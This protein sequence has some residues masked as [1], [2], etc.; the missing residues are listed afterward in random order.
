MTHAPL[1]HDEAQRL[2]ALDSLG[3]LDAAGSPAL[4]GLVRC[5]SAAT[6]CAIALVSLVDRDRQWVLSRVGLDVQEAPRNQSFCAHA[7]LEQGLFVVPDAKADARFADNPLVTG[8]PGIRFYAG[9]PL[10]VDGQ[11]MGTLCVADRQPH[12]LTA[13]Q[14]EVLVD[15]ARAAEQL[16][17][18]LRQQRQLRQLSTAVEQSS[19][20]ILITDLES[21]IVYVN[22]AAVKTSGYR[23]DELIGH[24]ARL[25][26]S[27]RTPP[28]AFRSLRAHLREGQPWKGLFFNRTKSG[29]E[30]TVSA[31]I[32][33]IRQADGKVAQYLAVMDDVTSSR[34]LGEE[35][36]RHRHHVDELV[37]ERTSELEQARLAA[38]AANEAKSAFLAAMSHEIRT[39]MNGVVGI[40]DVLRQSSLT[41]HQADLAG[42]IR[43]SSIAL[44][45]IIDDILDFSKAEAGAITL[46]PEPTNL[47]CLVESVC[48]MLQPMAAAR[49]VKV[50]VFVDP[51]LPRWIESDPLRLRQILHNLVGNAIKFSAGLDH[52]GRISVRFERDGEQGLRLRV[53]DNGIGISAQA[54]AAIFEPFDQGDRHTTRRYGG[55]GLGLA[56]CRRLVELFEGEISVDSIEGQG[57]TFSVTMPITAVRGPESEPDGAALDGIRCLV[58]LPDVEQ[59][60]DWCVYLDAAGA[61]ASAWSDLGE[62]RDALEVDADLPTVVLVDAGAHPGESD[63]RWWPPGSAGRPVPLVR[64]ELGQRRSPRLVDAGRVSLDADLVHR[65]AL[66]QAVLLAVGRPIQ[67]ATEAGRLAL[68]DAGSAATALAASDSVRLVLV[69]E[70]NEINQTV[71]RHQL[72][73][74]GFASEVV[75]NGLDALT[76][77]RRQRVTRRYALL[78]TD[79]QMP[80][81]DGCE[82]AATIRR[83]ELPAER[84]PIVAL[85]ANA[86]SEEALRCL[87]AG[88]DDVVTKPV[89]LDRLRKLLAQWLPAIEHEAPSPAPLPL[90]PVAPVLAARPGVLLVDDEPLE[91][92]I[93]ERQLEVMGAPPVKA[94]RSAR[95]AL[96]WLAERDTSAMLL[97]LDLSMPGMDGVEFMRHLADRGFSGAV[98][99]VSGADV[100]VLETATKLAEAYQLNVLSHLH[101][102]VPTETLRA[103]IDRWRGYVPVPASIQ[104]L[105]Y[106]VDEIRHAIAHNELTLHYQPKVSMADGAFVGVEALVRWQHPRDGMCLPASFVPSAEAN[107]LIDA[108]TRTVLSQALRQVRHWADRG[109]ALR[110]AVNVSMDN[111]VHLDFTEFVLD[112]AQRHG[113]PPTDLVLE[114]TESRLMRD[115]RS[116]MDILTRLRLKRIGLSIDDFG[117][118]HSSLAQLR[119]MPFDELKIDRGFVHGGREQATQRAILTAS[120]GM[121]HELGM[122]TVAEGVED[123]AD[124]D[125]AKAAGCDVAQGYFIARPMPASAVLG[126]EAQW[127]ERFDNFE[128]ST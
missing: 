31:V 45:G 18:G 47:L 90:G 104:G 50:R 95:D 51:A 105:V 30:V 122:Q 83:E 1:P 101:K 19:A 91:L 60:Q 88:M 41:P 44:L 89:E 12:E 53:R 120:V 73:L 39:P 36:E 103:L 48:D 113:V 15:L 35:L 118:G 92:Q 76:R 16:L 25:L 21:R 63:S 68:A 54:Q 117:T 126:W 38:E 57:T 33:P 106:G 8:E 69:A 14:K 97:L 111:L 77:W 65:D 125:I 112:E 7:I 82:L 4:D 11:P 29:R 10:K 98:A 3:L 40:L 74:L 121:A 96:Q 116:A 49:G 52:E 102:P 85:T 64:I 34:R 94:C 26:Q 62:L 37:Q 71:I 67:A 24:N 5:A 110:L 22:E 61:R 80:G 127:R 123:R 115:A 100:R 13:G 46:V 55:T 87:A 56:I 28:E 66:V 58:C 70:D 6:G 79:L 107:G 72:A 32:T 84:L 108:L 23:R 93:L 109:L 99:L 124:W 78:L 43:E 9:V 42:T 81:L 119:D 17:T 20:S 114:V 2:A 86:M 128:Q 75:G 59:A 27:G